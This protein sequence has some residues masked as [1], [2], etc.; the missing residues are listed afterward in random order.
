M[1]TNVVYAGQTYSV[2]AVGDSSWGANVSNYLIALA[3]GSL[4]K[5]GGA[6]TLTADANLGSSFGLISKYFT[7]V[8][9]NP[10]STGAVRLANGD[11]I[12]FRN[13]GNTADIALQPGAD[14]ILTYG[15]A[16]LL[17]AA[18]TATLTNKTISGASNTLSNIGYSSL[19]LTGSILNA[20]LA[21]SIAYSK[22]SLAG[23]ILNTDLAGSIAYSKLSLTGAILNA[24]L[25]GS[26]A[27]SKLVG[28]DITTVGTI[29]T[30][31]WAGTTIAVNHGGTGVTAST[32]A[33]SVMLRDGNQNVAI[34]NINEA[35]ATTTTA[36]GTTT[37]TVSSAPLQQFTGTTTQ[38]VALPAATTLVTGCQFQ[39][40]NRSAGVVAVK[41]GGGTT[42]QAMAA[43]SQLLLTC[44]A[45]GTAAGT[46]DLSY[47]IGAGSALPIASGGTGQTTQQAAINALTGTQS[48]GKYLRSDG[49]NATLA[50]IVAADVPAINLAA[51][52]GGGVTGNL[53][54]TNL[55]S[56]TGASSTTFWRGDG[57][58]ATPAGGTGGSGTVTSVAL[59]APTEFT[60]SGSPVTAAGTLTF[61][62]ATQSANTVWAGPTTGV[63]AA[64]T[65]RAL[66]SA[67]IPAINLAASG[68]GGVTGNL[69]VGNLNS[70]ASASSATFWRG[71][72][73]WATPSGASPLTTKG[74]LYTF[75]T[76]NARLGVGSD[77]QALVA[78]SSQTTGLR[79]ATL[80]QGAKNYISFNNFENNSTTGW[81]LGTAGTLTNG[82]PTGTPTFGSG[83]AVGLS[84][85]TVTSGQLAGTASLS[86]AAT[87]ATT[88]GNMLASQAYTI[89]I[90]D[91]A[92]VLAWKFYYQ[93]QAGAA[94][95]N[96]SGTSSNSFAVGI[97]DVT[98]SVWL[99]TPGAF[100]LVQSSGVGIAQGTFQTGSTTAS[101][102]LVLYF[103][104]ATAGAATLYLDDFYVGPQALAFGPAV[105][106]PQAYTATISTGF[107]T[108]T[109]VTTEYARDGKWLIGTFQF[110]AGTMAG[111]VASIS[112]PAG[113]AIDTAA[114]SAN[115]VVGR[116]GATA[117]P[118]SGNL[119]LQTGTSTSLIYFSNGSAA[120]N[121]TITASAAWANGTG[122]SG[123]FAVPIAGWSSNTAMS[124]DT[125]TRVVAFRALSSSALTVV[126]NT[127]TTVPFTSG[128]VTADTAGSWDTTNNWYLAAVTGYYRVALRCQGPSG[129]SYVQSA[130]RVNSGT[131]VIIGQGDGSTS[132]V[133]GSYGTDIVKLNAGDKL[134]FRTASSGT[135]VAVMLGTVERLSGPAVVAA[136][137]SVYARYGGTTSTVTA[138]IA[139]PNVIIYNTKRRDTHNAYSVSTGLFTCPVSGMYR[140]TGFIHATAA[141]LAATNNFDIQIQQNA[142]TVSA[143]YFNAMTTSSID[144]TFMVTDSVY[145][146]AGDTLGIYAG[147]NMSGSALTLDNSATRT[148]A[149]FERIGN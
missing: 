32:G 116:W 3:S 16:A 41:D 87:G 124:A 97:W 78:D 64:P 106:D 75:T 21:G 94:N 33:S 60:V 137:E 23:A 76:A 88:A 83:A 63:A 108:A 146:A 101:I 120:Y 50:S 113:L 24:D 53:P 126:A 69:A 144:R 86:L 121:G 148:Y 105:S 6:F 57:T 11:S 118:F 135:S 107:G 123:Q 134:Q 7:S 34:N 122:F 99:Q 12:S 55:N 110:T 72:G 112:I 139:S 65:F 42:L 49:S 93:A 67:D 143:A 18:A 9:A 81:S 58:W 52:G 128:Q 43:G 149:T 119:F 125:D 89:D 28:S 38:N 4:T 103:P 35:F 138:T 26:I 95:C 74:D 136:T 145:C 46:W 61:A 5:A 2:P 17:T 130:Y 142:A 114:I 47:T 82:L 85:A 132:W 131:D 77:N 147:Q 56:G 45:N 1:A 54:V 31:T 36:A 91:Q 141:A 29:A 44:A 71:D 30:G 68:A 48:S 98:N 14:G 117:T 39:I 133:S 92:K 8:S 19:T 25:A 90:E 102:R 115:G 104:N 70:G 20:D 111:A 80:Q 22:L 129:D 40:F 84:I 96:F 15:G 62:K 10:A 59:S 109:A 127:T 37:L 13:V 51:S 66:V 140:V 27:A 73:T 79:W 100:N